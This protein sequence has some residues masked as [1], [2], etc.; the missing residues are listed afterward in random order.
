LENASVTDPLTGLHNR[1]HLRQ[2]LESEIAALNR[3]NQERDR[4]SES[5]HALDLSPGLAFMMIDLDGF[6]PINDTYGHHAGDLAL[7]QV[8]DI[9]QNCCRQSDTIVRWGGDE[10]FIVGRHA[11][12]LGAEKYA[13]RI[14]AE[15]ANHQFHVG[16][17]HVARLSGSIGVTMYPFALHKPQQFSWEQVATIADQAAYLAKEN[18]R[19]AWVGLYGTRKI[20]SEDVYERLNTD[21]EGLV[22]QGMVDVTT[23]IENALVFSNRVQQKNA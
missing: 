18:G 13:E 4:E 14:R 20:S 16:G 22:K 17:G 1:R 5:S 8:R 7:M 10:F 12:R 11:N 23:S 9:L 21:L 19:N 3:V 15:L 2:Y 6:K